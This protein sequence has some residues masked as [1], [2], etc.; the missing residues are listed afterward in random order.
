MIQITIGRGINFQQCP[1][2]KGLGRVHKSGHTIEKNDFVIQANTIVCP[3]CSG[4]RIIPVNDKKKVFQ[5]S[6]KT[7]L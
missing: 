1:Q 7:L 5:K 2:C 3:V 4:K 6:E